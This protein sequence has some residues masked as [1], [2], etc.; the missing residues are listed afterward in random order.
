MDYVNTEDHENTGSKTRFNLADI[1]SQSFGESVSLAFKNF[2]STDLS[3]SGMNYRTDIF[4]EQV[5]TAIKSVDTPSTMK[6]SLDF[7]KKNY[8]TPSVSKLI[9]HVDSGS[10][11]KD[12]AGEYQGKTP[13]ARSLIDSDRYALDSVFNYNDTATNNAF[14][15][16]DEI[17][18]EAKV[19][20]KEDFLSTQR[21]LENTEGFMNGVA[22]MAGTMGAAMTD[23][24]ILA[25]LPLGGTVKM[26]GTGLA[27]VTKTAG[28]AALQEAKIAALAEVPIQLSVY[29][30][31]KEIGIDYTVYDAIIN[32]TIGIASAGIL[33]AG[34]SAFIDVT[35]TVLS[36][37]KKQA[38][39]KGD[40]ETVDIIDDYV[41][42]NKRKA[43]DNPEEHIEIMNETRRAIEENDV[44]D[45]ADAIRRSESQN[46]MGKQLEEM[47]IAAKATER[48]D[49]VT[50]RDLMDGAANR[51]LNDVNQKP[52]QMQKTG[53]DDMPVVEKEVTKA[54]PVK[55]EPTLE[56]KTQQHDQLEKMQLEKEGRSDY[57]DAKYQE[58]DEFL[59]ALEDD[60]ILPEKVIDE[61]GNAVMKAT[62]FKEDIGRL[63]DDENTINKMWECAI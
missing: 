44:V 17:N 8:Y 50:V 16:Q 25:T 37:F 11:Y 46:N 43:V 54:K 47:N 13:F 42:M 5:D 28:V 18:E 38:Q 39:V 36:K 30:W 6:E 40:V 24:L 15:T 3:T 56:V 19:Q 21:K 22:K 2:A 9:H 53:T 14:K 57:V 31:K 26:T 63:T 29:D 27:A 4:N 35:P 61:D 52:M 48:P 60:I 20:S 55:K 10:I 7:Y 49:E 12:D 41:A 23:P 51:P 1:G 62:S 32:G 45:I 33:R 59:K 34:G 58:A